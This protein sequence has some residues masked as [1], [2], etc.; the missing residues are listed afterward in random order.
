VAHYTNLDLSAYAP[1]Y[2]VHLESPDPESAARVMVSW[3]GR[4]AVALEEGATPDLD[5]KQV[6]KI[7]VWLTPEGRVLKV[8]DRLV[9]L[10]RSAQDG[11][12]P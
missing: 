5:R 8:G 12:A 2:L 11:S 3:L 9:W 4:E 7:E 10:N 6:L 1:G